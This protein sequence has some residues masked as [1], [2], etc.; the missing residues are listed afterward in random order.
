MAGYSKV[1][2]YFEWADELGAI[3]SVFEKMG[4]V[5]STGEQPMVACERFVNS[6]AYSPDSGYVVDFGNSFV[7][8][9]GQYHGDKDAF[10]LNYESF[11]ALHNIYEK[12]FELPSDPLEVQIENYAAS[13]F[14]PK[15]ISAILRITDVDEFIIA[16]NTDGQYNAAYQRG[17][18]RSKAKIHASIIEQAQNGSSK[19]AELALK[20]DKEKDI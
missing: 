2:V 15:E 12:R 7:I 20:I 10:H 4:F 1:K 17:Y 19:A 11:F 8:E 6:K 13:L 5:S 14:S 3:M 16:C 9:A 18:L